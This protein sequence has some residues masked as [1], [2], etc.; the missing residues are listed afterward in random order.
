MCKV[1]CWRWLFGN[2]IPISPDGTLNRTE[3]LTPRP[4][5]PPCSPEFL[6]TCAPLP[7]EPLGGLRVFRS[8]RLQFL[9]TWPNDTPFRRK[10]CRESIFASG[11]LL[12]WR[13]LSVSAHAVAKTQRDGNFRLPSRAYW[14]RQ[15]APSCLPQG[16][17]PRR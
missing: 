11:S 7:S 12:I 2:N 8:F 15:S 1:R 9:P 4:S 14:C 6:A 13:G 5:P 16:A 17:A 3:T 10:D